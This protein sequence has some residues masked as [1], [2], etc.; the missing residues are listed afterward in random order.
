MNIKAYTYLVAIEE[1]RSLSKAAEKLG[2]SQPALS[3]FLANAETTL[4]H[5]LFIKSKKSMIPTEAGKIYLQAC[6]QI[7]NIKQ[8]TYASLTH[9]SNTPKEVIT[10]GLTPYRGSQV[11]SN[12][13]PKFS[14]RYPHIEIRL[15]EG[16]MQELKEEV[17]E[18][19]VDMVI[20]TIV[21]ADERFYNFASTG[22]EELCVVVPLSHPSAEKSNDSGDFFPVIDIR[23]LSDA[24]F[25]MW[26][27]S[28]TNSRIIDEYLTRNRFTPTVIYRGNN[29][30]IVDE[31]L[32]TGIG[33]GF[34]P[35]SFCKPGEGRVYFSTWP[36]VQS[37]AGIFYKKNRIL[38]EAERYFIYLLMKHASDTFTSTGV[39]VYFNRLSRSIINEFEA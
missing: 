33:V 37:F 18:G 10:L 22:Y 21:P 3:K 2:I 16:Y 34:L 39:N 6:R 14:E 4:G 19:T 8:Q 11:F 32:K 9:L 5:Q 20:G 25:V 23:T 1:N 38:S 28:T 17:D 36:P 29:A 31:M 7:I 30:L 12:I 24:P 27:Y 35:R 26:G 15:K 13:Y